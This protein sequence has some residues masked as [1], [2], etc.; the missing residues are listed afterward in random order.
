MAVFG[1]SFRLSG[2]TAASRSAATVLHCTTMEGGEGL[3][4]IFLHGFNGFRV[5]TYCIVHSFCSTLN[6]GTVK[7]DLGMLLGS[8][9]PQSVWQNFCHV[10]SWSAVLSSPAAS[11]WSLV[12]MM[13][14]STI[15]PAAHYPW[16]TDGQRAAT[17]KHTSF[18][19]G[20]YILYCKAVYIPSLRLWCSMA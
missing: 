12:F 20:Q 17:S 11:F 14:V 15:Q 13:S 18:S 2:L 16:T 10:M 3:G 7:W 5:G 6:C 1:Y 8:S 4:F 19:A 9:S